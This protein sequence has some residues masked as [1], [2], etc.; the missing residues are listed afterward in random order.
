VQLHDKQ[1]AWIYSGKSFRAVSPLGRGARPG[2]R[3]AYKK[4]E[5][6]P[7]STQVL[8]SSSDGEL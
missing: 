3:L 2:D 5:T 7:G 4:Q 1:A 8:V 6:T